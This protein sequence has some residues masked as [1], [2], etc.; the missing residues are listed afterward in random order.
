MCTIYNV[1]VDVAYFR[2][3]ILDLAANEVVIE[4]K[5]VFIIYMM[6]NVLLKAY[7]IDV[8]GPGTVDRLDRWLVAKSISIMSRKDAAYQRYIRMRR[9]Y[10]R[11]LIVSVRRNC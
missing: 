5:L 2:N 6:A 8:N 3:K 1:A 9:K 11:Y 4:N 7:N 10:L